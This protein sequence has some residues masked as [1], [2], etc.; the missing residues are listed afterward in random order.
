MSEGNLGLDF[1]IFMQIWIIFYLCIF[2]STKEASLGTD[3][4]SSGP[5]KASLTLYEAYSGL[6]LPLTHPHF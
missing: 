2:L 4:T 6:A 1:L 5:L 3:E